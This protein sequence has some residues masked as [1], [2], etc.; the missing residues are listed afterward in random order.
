MFR[1][2]QKL[3]IFLSI[4]TIFFLGC[5]SGSGSDSSNNSQPEYDYSGVWEGTWHSTQNSSEGIFCLEIQQNGDQVSG[6]IYLITKGEETGFSGQIT[7][8]GFVLAKS[9]NWEFTATGDTVQL[10][11]T[12]QMP[13]DQG[14][15]TAS[16]NPNKTKCDW[17]SNDVRSYFQ[18]ILSAAG[19]QGDAAL[20]ASLVTI[21]P[22]I[23]VKIN[24]QTAQ[25]WLACIWEIDDQVNNDR[26]TL[27]AVFGKHPGLN[28]NAAF[29][30]TTNVI[31]QQNSNITQQALFDENI[32]NGIGN[33]GPDVYLASSGSYTVTDDRDTTYTNSILYKSPCVNGQQIEVRMTDLSGTFQMTATNISGN[34][35]NILMSSNGSFQNL[36]ALHIVIKPCQ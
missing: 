14:E 7:E 20:L 13:D 25:D 29:G 5:S 15:W 18:N 36:G 12:Y 10:S 21:V 35:V 2:I 30:W 31:H 16:K 34:Q 9:G 28:T 11:G 27:G 17:A 3:V 8:N 26:Y 22:V 19:N 32:D 1:L 23:D 4:M 6:T 33:F 24:D